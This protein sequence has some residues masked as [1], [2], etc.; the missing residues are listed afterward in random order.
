MGT[1]L[2]NQELPREPRAALSCFSVEDAA[3]RSATQ[4]ISLLAWNEFPQRNLPSFSSI[5]FDVLLLL[6]FSFWRAARFV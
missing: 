5:E 1:L 2:W 3:L 4:I 6:L